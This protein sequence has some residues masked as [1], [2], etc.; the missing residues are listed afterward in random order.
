[1]QS[2]QIDR[3]YCSPNFD[4][5]PP[6]STIDML[7]LHY[8]AVDFERSIEILCDPHN[9]LGRVSA[10]YVIDLDGRI[11][12]LV[13]DQNRAWHAGKSAWRGRTSLNGSSIGIEVVNPG[14]DVTPR[15]PYREAQIESIIALSRGLIERYSI[16]AHNIVGHSDI[17]PTR[18]SD[19]GEHFPWQR[20]AEAGVGLQTTMITPQADAMLRLPDLIEAQALLAKIGYQVPQTG[21]LCAHTEAVVRAFQM[22]F[23][24][25]AV[26]GALCEQTLKTLPRIASSFPQ[27]ATV[28]A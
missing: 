21:I 2:L 1:M 23:V 26:S 19:P 5:R 3:R 10:H 7:V 13:D 18:K 12:Q 24:Q 6:G 16:P 25:N 27:D 28:L 9:P 4:D 22:R 8:T 14:H 11:Y 20:L 17:A 15:V